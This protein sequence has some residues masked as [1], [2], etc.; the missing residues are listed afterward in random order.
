MQTPSATPTDAHAGYRYYAMLMAAFVTVIVASNFIGPAKACRIDLPFALPFVGETLTFGAGNIFFPLS[1]IFGDVLTEVY[2]YAKA[3]KVIWAGFASLLFVT[4]MSFRVE[5]ADLAELNGRAF[6]FM[7]VG[8]MASP[9]IIL[10]LIEVT[11]GYSVPLLAIAALNAV[12]A[13]VLLWR[14]DRDGGGLPSG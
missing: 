7:S 1:Y 5:S 10:A 4:A 9:P 2:G 3:R 8:W 14:G 11:G 6:A 12:V 13:S